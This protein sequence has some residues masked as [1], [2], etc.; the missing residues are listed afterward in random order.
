M[1]LIRLVQHDTC[2]ATTQCTSFKSMHIVNYYKNVH[3]FFFKI[4]LFKK[5]LFINKKIN[6][7][8]N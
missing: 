6:N 8:E 2:M 7:L 4:Q 5:K 3:N 1:Y